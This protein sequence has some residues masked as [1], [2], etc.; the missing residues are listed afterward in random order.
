MPMDVLPLLG[1]VLAAG[2]AALFFL[3]GNAMQGRQVS[4]DA[5]PA[6][7]AFVTWWYGIGAVSLVGVLMGLPW[8][9]AD[10]G[11]HLAL[12]GL[13]LVV[14]CV[15]LTGLMQYLVFLY[16]SRNLLV[17]IA[18]G[19]AVM[20]AVFVAYLVQSDPVGI[21]V[22]RWGTELQM[23]NEITR[24]P[25]YWALIVLLLVP[26]IVAGAAYLSL[27]RVAREPFMRRRILLVS[28]S[29]MLWFGS[30]LF[31]LAPGAQEA[32]WW[33]VAS[34]LIGLAAAG[35]ILY[36]YTGLRPSAPTGH[37]PADSPDEESLY[38]DPTRRVS[39]VLHA[40]VA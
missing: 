2:S 17:W 30:S 7:L 1:L 22:T 24:G 5:R 21:E 11:L 34:R 13:L 35:T 18:L 28:L 38:E 37:A 16:T 12:T 3:V 26:P 39:S 20:F 31:G 4:P 40:T 15:A 10:L 19:Y 23:A 8:F 32:D 25:L 14:L 27:L 36:A 6:Q 33:R 29:V 9:P